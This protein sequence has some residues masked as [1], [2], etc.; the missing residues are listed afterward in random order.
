[1]AA[2]G[3]KRFAT[4]S[5]SEI[6]TKRLN[7]HSENTTKA[8]KRAAT[9]LRDYLKENSQNTNFEALDANALAEVLGHFY[10]DARK[11]DGKHYKSSS[12]ENVRHGLNRY[13]KDPPHYKQ[14]DIIKDTAFTNANA[15]FKAAMAELKRLG[16]GATD[17]YP[18]ISEE[19][20]RK[21]YTSVHTSPQ[22]PLGLFNKVQ[23]DLRLYFCRRG[24]ENI[25]NFTKD[26]FQVSTDPNTG[27]FK[28]QIPKL[29]TI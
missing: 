10:L 15:N 7:M 24:S 28:I 2:A 18:T 8:N 4:N 13:L 14:F 27:N 1:M 12:L 11:V 6:A 17:H 21:V 25:Y 16:L 29:Q 22:T 26:T 23:F 9:A 3:M 5:E 19:D 20:R